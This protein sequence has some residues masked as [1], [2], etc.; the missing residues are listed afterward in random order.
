VNFGGFGVILGGGDLVLEAKMFRPE[1]YFEL[2]NFKATHLRQPGVERLTQ[3][4]RMSRTDATRRRRRFARQQRHGV[5]ERRIIVRTFGA[6]FAQHQQTA[7]VD[8]LDAAHTTLCGYR[9][10]C[11]VGDARNGGVRSAMAP[12]WS[13]F[14]AMF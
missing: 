11:G 2:L 4:L 12:A 6:W 13:Q 8:I 10:Y 7:A 9:R 1:R 5:T 3:G 14:A